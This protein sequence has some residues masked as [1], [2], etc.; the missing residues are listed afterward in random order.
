MASSED[1][2]LLPA[3][4]RN[5]ELKNVRSN[6]FQ[7]GSK[8]ELFYSIL[9]QLKAPWLKTL[10]MH[11]LD[12]ISKYCAWTV[13]SG[14]NEAGGTFFKTAEPVNK[15]NLKCEISLLVYMPFHEKNFKKRNWLANLHKEKKRNGTNKQRSLF[16]QNVPPF[17]LEVTPSQM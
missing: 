3:K 11:A 8:K 13:L 4:R 17:F 1:N 14:L 10:T 15:Y 16:I 6:S 9:P 12:F 5:L 7:P 2:A